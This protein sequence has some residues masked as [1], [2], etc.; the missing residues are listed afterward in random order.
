MYK[1]AKLAL[2]SIQQK[3]L[4]KGLKVKVPKADIGRGALIMLHPV[5]FKKIMSAKGAVMIELSPGEIIATASHHGLVPKQPDGMDGGSIWSSIWDGI[6]KVGSFVKDSG[7]GSIL[8]DTAATAAVPFVGPGIAAAG[9]QLLRNQT[10]VGLAPPASQ[11]A[12]LPLKA[13]LGKPGLKG[14][15]LYLARAAGSGLYL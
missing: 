12:A 13:K 7:I 2:S 9:R 1:S 11:E 5:N 3:K 10:G 14:K 8:A 4:L 6:K 15:G